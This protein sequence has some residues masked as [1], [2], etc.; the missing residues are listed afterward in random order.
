M[1]Y[2]QLLFRCIAAKSNFIQCLAQIK[3]V[4]TYLQSRTVSIMTAEEVKADDI[5][6][7]SILA[8]SLPENVIVHPLVLLSVVDHYNRLART[9]QK[10]AVGVL[11]GQYDK[12]VYNVANSFAGKEEAMLRHST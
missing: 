3:T 12:G 6:P 2:R 8:K 9:N 10:R 7:L 5:A 4:Q 1:T 11:L